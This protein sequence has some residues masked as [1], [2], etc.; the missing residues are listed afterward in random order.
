M[1]NHY[2]ASL[3]YQADP[4]RGA[5]FQGL[6][7][8]RIER[9]LRTSTDPGWAAIRDAL[10]MVLA[11][12][13]ANAIDA[14]RIE[15]ERLDALDAELAKDPR[16]QDLPEVTSHMLYQQWVGPREDTAMTVREDTFP[17]RLSWLVAQD[18]AHLES[19]VADAYARDDF[20]I[21]MGHLG[22]HNGPFDCL[23]DDLDEWLAA[24][25][26]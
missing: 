13:F 11:R 23:L 14:D 16:Y 8:D 20:A 17:V 5:E 3:A 4:A 21:A 26:T 19:L 9:Y 24:T 1:T 15:R 12:V 7:K 18:R 25:A 2:L 10:P 6:P 22:D